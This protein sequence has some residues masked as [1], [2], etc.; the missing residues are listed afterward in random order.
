[1]QKNIFKYANFY[2]A[3]YINKPIR[4][5]CNTNFLHKIPSYKYTNFNN[6]EN[7]KNN[8]IINATQMKTNK[9]IKTILDYS[10]PIA[11][12]S[13]IS[14]NYAYGNVFPLIY[15]GLT[16]LIGQDMR[17]M[18]DISKPFQNVLGI[19]SIITGASIMFLPYLDHSINA[20]LFRSLENMVM[21]TSF[22]N[23][24]TWIMIGSWTKWTVINSEHKL[25]SKKQDST[26]Q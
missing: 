7:N 4:P 10:Q 3:R 18:P 12:L 11:I 23:W 6:N 15:G 8:E 19:S 20:E 5:I 14:L 17:T 13:A 2:C 16:I 24:T 26:L 9:Y 1:M 21:Y 22:A 25:E